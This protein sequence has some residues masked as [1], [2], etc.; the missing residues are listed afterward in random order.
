[1]KIPTPFKRPSGSWTVRVRIN[2]VQHSI[3]RPTK[4]ACIKEAVKLKTGS[5][6]P[7]ADDLTVAQALKSYIDSRENVL[8]PATIRGYRIIQRNRFKPIMPLKLSSLSKPV[9]QKAVNDEATRISAKTLK[10]SAALIESVYLEFTGEKLSAKIPKVI[11]KDL[12]YLT[13]DQIEVFVR[14]I[15][16]HK[17]EIPMLLALSSLRH[18][19]IVAVQRKDID[20]R[21]ETLTV[22]G[23]A[24]RNDSGELIYKEENKNDTSRRVIPFLIPRLA[25]LI[26]Q[27]TFAPDEYLYPHYSVSLRNSINRV[28]RKNGLPEVGVHGLRRSYASLC[29]HLG[30]P[31]SIIMITGGWASPVVLDKRYKKVPQADVEKQ[32]EKLTNFYESAPESALGK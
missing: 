22:C 12:P 24:V 30:I 32:G 31:D 7:I 16:G 20:L 23:A 10:N 15:H 25:E 19:E 5:K 26:E 11:P 4:Q 27:S 6:A 1:M 29:H 9:W 18:S 3:T 13:P 14:A 8:S 2:G 21:A 17:C 28:C